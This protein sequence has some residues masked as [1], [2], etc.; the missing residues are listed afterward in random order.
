MYTCNKETQYLHDCLSLYLSQ[1]PQQQMLEH[2]SLFWKAPQVDNGSKSQCLHLQ[3]KY[4]TA[5]FIHL[6]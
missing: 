1:R 4:K 2:R 3:Q 6:C 5:Q